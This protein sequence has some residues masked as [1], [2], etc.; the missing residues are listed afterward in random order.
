MSAN[1]PEKPGYPR[2][3]Y[4]AIARADPPWLGPAS[5]VART[6]ASKMLRPRSERFEEGACT[7]HK[8]GHG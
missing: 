6:L 4:Q 2:K 7:H 3:W 1:M 8:T 5:G